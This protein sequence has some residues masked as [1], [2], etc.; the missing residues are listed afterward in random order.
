[1]E[2]RDYITSILLFGL[3]ITGISVFMAEAA[4]NTGNSLDNLTYLAPVNEITAAVTDVQNSI[5]NS[6]IT[7]TLLDI[8]LMVISGLYSLVKLL[9]VTLGNVW[10]TFTSGLAAFLGVPEWAVIIIQA[11]I[12]TSISFTILKILFNRSTDI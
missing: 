5:T 4:T 2:L 10:V 1:M 11:I 8:P 12:I 9:M 6:Q 3:V 7:G